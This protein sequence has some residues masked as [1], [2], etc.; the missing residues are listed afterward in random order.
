MLEGEVREREIAIYLP[1][2]PPAASGKASRT[3]PSG[4][5]DPAA[6]VQRNLRGR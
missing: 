6:G 4:S 5:G 1:L 3:L 2:R